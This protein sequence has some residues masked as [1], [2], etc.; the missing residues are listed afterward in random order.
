[1]Y[2][3]RT[4][5]PGKERSGMRSSRALINSKQLKRHCSLMSLLLS[6]AAIL[7]HPHT[8]SRSNLRCFVFQQTGSRPSPAAVPSSGKCH[9]KLE[10]P[11][12]YQS[13]IVKITTPLSVML[14]KTRLCTQQ[15]PFPTSRHT[16]THTHTKHT[17]SHAVSPHRG[18]ELL[19]L[20]PPIMSIRPRIQSALP[21][22]FE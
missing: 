18:L 12:S 8:Q 11:S 14:F 7:G 16:K 1:M 2:H 9:F 20:L 21:V 13:C 22:F 6:A 3:T 10:Q 17:P 15:P 4:N 5:I 19:P